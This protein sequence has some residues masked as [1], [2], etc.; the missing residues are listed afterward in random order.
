MACGDTD[1]SKLNGKA[2]LSQYGSKLKFGNK[3]KFMQ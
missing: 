3:T 2:Y 1:A